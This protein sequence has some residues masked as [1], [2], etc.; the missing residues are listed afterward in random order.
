MQM[1]LDDIENIFQNIIQLDV[2]GTK[3]QAYNL[4]GS[5]SVRFFPFFMLCKVQQNATVNGPWC[6]SISFTFPSYSD[7]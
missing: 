2:V 6:I 7:L 5:W 3:G 1:D 4:L